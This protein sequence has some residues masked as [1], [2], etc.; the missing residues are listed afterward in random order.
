MIHH[1][2]LLALGTL[3]LLLGCQ[4]RLAEGTHLATPDE[5]LTLSAGEHLRADRRAPDFFTFV[6]VL[7]DSR[8]PRGVQCIQAGRAVVSVQ[9]L[10]DGAL[11]EDTVTIDG[12]AITTDQGPLQL[13]ELEPYPDASVP[14][15]G[16]YRL[17]VRLLE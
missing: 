5:A 17:K 6:K 15:P 11:T 10:R 12:N 2:L 13:L 3:L 4:R 8:C 14:D 1:H 16:P 9:V 7:E